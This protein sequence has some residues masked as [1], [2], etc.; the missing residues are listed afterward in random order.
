MSLRL[1]ITARKRWAHEILD[2]VKAGLPVLPIQIRHALIALG[3]GV[4]HG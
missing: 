1:N 4:D 2:M 3:D